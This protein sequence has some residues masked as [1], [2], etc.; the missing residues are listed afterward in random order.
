MKTVNKI[1]VAVDFSDFSF[2]AIRYAAGLA[3]DVGASL[4]LV[5]VINRRDLYLVEKIA[6]RYP[7]FS[8]DKYL[9]ETRLNR[10]NSFR[11]LIN[12]GEI[13]DLNVT[14]QIRQGVPCEE[15]LTAIREEKAD[16][17]VM[18]TKGRSNLIDT[19]IGSCAQK[20]FRL[21][22]IPVLSVRGAVG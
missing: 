5:N 2:P 9:R 22:P 21:S 15:L 10:E 7:T 17:L 4:L 19:V 8:V 12:A 20:M 6:M 11:E 1:L 14:T 3:R 18:A 16:M 13:E